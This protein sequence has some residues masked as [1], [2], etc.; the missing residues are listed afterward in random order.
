MDKYSYRLVPEN[1]LKLLIAH[2]L[3]YGNLL[4]DLWEQDIAYVSTNAECIAR[5]LNMPVEEVN[6]KGYD[7][8]TIAEKRLENFEYVKK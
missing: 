2:N 1:Y 4:E 3:A 5:E 6:E 8:Y 7:F